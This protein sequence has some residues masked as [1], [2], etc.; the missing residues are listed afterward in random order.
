MKVKG[1]HMQQQAQ[2]GRPEGY[3]TLQAVITYK[4]PVNALDFYKKALGATEKFVLKGPRDQGIA[5]AEL[6]IGDSVFMIGGESEEMG[7]RSVESYG[8]SGVAFHVYVPDVDAAYK[9]ALGNGCKSKKEV[10]EAFWGER[11]GT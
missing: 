2:S 7:C 6:K 11:V 1:G 9:K 5:H 10:W 3:H 4:D 8:G